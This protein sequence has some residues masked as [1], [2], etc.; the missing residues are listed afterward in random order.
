MT[1]V[2]TTSEIMN[3]LTKV[4]KPDLIQPIEEEE[5]EMPTRKRR[6]RDVTKHGQRDCVSYGQILNSVAQEE[7]KPL[8]IKNILPHMPIKPFL[9][10]NPEGIK[11]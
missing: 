2:Q 3:L 6:K 11:Q 4:R 8:K 5:E 1:A 10:A 9:S 7:Y